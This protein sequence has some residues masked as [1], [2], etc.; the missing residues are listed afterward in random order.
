MIIGDVTLLDSC[1]VFQFLVLPY[2]TLIWKQKMFMNG[3]MDIIIDKRTCKNL[4]FW[5]HQCE[6]AAGQHKQCGM[7][8]YFRVAALHGCFESAA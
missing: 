2:V 4:H 6:W 5:H 8:S 3:W 1:K 7:V